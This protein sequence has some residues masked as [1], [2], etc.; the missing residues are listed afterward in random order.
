MSID[1]KSLVVSAI[2]H[3][4][5]P[6]LPYTFRWEEQCDVDQ[7]LDAF[8]GSRDWRRR[9]R[10]YI[11]LVGNLDDGRHVD[12]PGPPLRKNHYGSVWR[13]DKRPVHLEEPALKQP[14]LKGYTFPDLDTLF[15][16]EWEKEV[17]KA[18]AENSDC[19]TVLNPGFGLF[20]RSWD[21][22]GYAQVLMDCAAEPA[23]FADLIAAI[24]EH[25]EKIIE[26][27]L[28][29]PVDGIFFGDDWGDQRG[30]V[31]GPDRWRAVIKPHY[32]HLYA[33]VK[34]AGKFVLHHSCGS[35]FDII[36][37][38]IEIGMDVLESV[39]PEAKNMN[40]YKLK[41]LFGD[42]IAFWGGLGSQSIIPCGT[43]QD[44][45]EEIQRL[46]HHMR[47][48]GGYILSG[49]KPLQPE[50]PVEN[51]AALLEEFVALGEE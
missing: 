50:T 40:P 8:Y 4:E 35:V 29:F 5:T 44:I 22:R 41:E 42:R 18:I 27:Q 23:F 9:F 1:R 43:P 49:A 2:Q 20:E 13:T 51:A 25:Q 38:A 14:S 39:Q 28:G 12:Q 46:A 47:K 10:S 21:L 19:F 31:M 36:P 6:L 16:P 11:A 3:K 33:K 34:A 32:A 48:G 37:D 45:R 15:P 24:A 30:V 26:F 7:R 17:H